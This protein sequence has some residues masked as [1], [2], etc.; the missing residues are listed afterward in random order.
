MAEDPQ[1]LEKRLEKQQASTSRPSRLMR[2]RERGATRPAAPPTRRQSGRDGAGTPRGAAGQDRAGQEERKEAER[3]ADETESQRSQAAS[4]LRRARRTELAKRRK[5]L[6]KAEAGLAAAQALDAA[7]RPGHDPSRHRAIAADE[8]TGKEDGGPQVT[9]EED[10][11]QPDGQQAIGPHD[12]REEDRGQEDR[13]QEDR[14][15]PQ[16]SP[17]ILQLRALLSRR[18]SRNQRYPKPG[19]GSVEQA[20]HTRE[21]RDRRGPPRRGPCPLCCGPRSAVRARRGYDGVGVFRV[22]VGRLREALVLRSSRTSSG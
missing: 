12:D 1:L 5:K 7:Q 13:R 3:L 15:H 9:C 10:P 22:G 19:D 4:D 16:S 17:P 11:G 2:W 20:H 21:S 8:G 6:A 14:H 18:T